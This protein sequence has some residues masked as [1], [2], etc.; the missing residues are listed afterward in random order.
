MTPPLQTLESKYKR[1]PHRHVKEKTQC[2]YP[3]F[4]ACS[5]VCRVMSGTTMRNWPEMEARGMKVG[6]SN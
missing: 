4:L 2:I 6:V 3:K 5:L 1:R